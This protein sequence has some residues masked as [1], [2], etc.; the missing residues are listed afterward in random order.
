MGILGWGVHIKMRQMR[1]LCLAWG[2]CCPLYWLI[3]VLPCP[4]KISGPCW[5]CLPLRPTSP[6]ALGFIWLCR[7]SLN[8]SQVLFLSIIYSELTF[9]PCHPWPLHRYHFSIPSKQPLPKGG[10]PQPAVPTGTRP[11][12]CVMWCRQCVLT[13][14]N[15]CRL[16][17]LKHVHLFFSSSLHV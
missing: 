4:F 2:G 17:N 1:F 14:Y 12:L 5:S 11:C 15:F 7:G 9:G 3:S 8:P 13:L 10:L 16:F 6:G